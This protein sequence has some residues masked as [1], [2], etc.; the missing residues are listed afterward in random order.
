[1]YPEFILAE[2]LQKHQKNELAVV[3]ADT[4]VSDKAPLFVQ[5]IENAAEPDDEEGSQSMTTK[6]RSMDQALLTSGIVQSISSGSID[7]VSVLVATPQRVTL[8]WAGYPGN[9]PNKLSSE[10]LEKFK[11]LYDIGKTNKKLTLCLYE[12]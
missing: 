2:K 4:F 7:A 5:S 1:M 3:V 10:C 11:E 9:N 6:A 12:R 8:K